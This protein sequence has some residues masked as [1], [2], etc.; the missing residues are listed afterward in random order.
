MAKWLRHWFLISTPWVRVPL[1][2]E[3]GFVT[4]GLECALDKRKVGSSNLLEPF[5]TCLDKNDYVKKKL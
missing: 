2:Q 1:L 4:Q 3:K 5:F